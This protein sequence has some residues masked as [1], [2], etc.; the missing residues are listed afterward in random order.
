MRKVYPFFFGAGITVMTG[1]ARAR[2]YFGL[3]IHRF[4]EGWGVHPVMLVFSYDKECIGI[5]AWITDCQPDYISGHQTVRG[6][7]QV[8]HPVHRLLSVVL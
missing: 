1:W 5:G 2:N 3:T 6:R 4:K 8:F 7:L